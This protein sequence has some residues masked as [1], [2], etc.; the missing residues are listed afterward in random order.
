[1]VLTE[2]SRQVSRVMMIVMAT[3]VDVGLSWSRSRDTRQT[4]T[5]HLVV[6]VDT[7]LDTTYTPYAQW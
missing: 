4:G 1:M 7:L 5:R 3:D 6:V 2:S